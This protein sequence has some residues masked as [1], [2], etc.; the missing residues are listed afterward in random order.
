MA[1]PKDRRLVLL[2]QHQLDALVDG[3]KL[4]LDGILSARLLA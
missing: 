3:R 4:L 2:L 1:L